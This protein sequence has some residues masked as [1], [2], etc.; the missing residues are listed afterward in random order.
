MKG[1]NKNTKLIKQ[2]KKTTQ[3]KR[4]K[5]KIKQKQ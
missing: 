1:T 2:E 5:K 4:K 3:S